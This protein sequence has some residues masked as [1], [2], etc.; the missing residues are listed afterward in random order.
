MSDLPIVNFDEIY[1]EKEYLFK[2]F[3][4]RN[5]SFKD[6]KGGDGPFVYEG[7]C[8]AICRNGMGSIYI[9]FKEY[10]LKAGMM[11]VILPYSIVQPAYVSVDCES[12]VMLAGVNLIDDI[13]LTTVMPLFQEIQ[14][15]PVTTLTP[16]QEKQ[17]TQ[18]LACA[19]RTIAD[20][21][22]PYT[23]EIVRTLL[24]AISLEICSVFSNKER[25]RRP[26][27]R[28]NHKEYIFKQFFNDLSKHYIEHH[29][30]SFY[31]EL[32]YMT[33]KYL[34]LV[35][36]DITGYTASYW[37]DKM[38]ILRAKSLLRHDDISIQQ[39]SYQLNFPNPSFFGQYF[40]KHVGVTPRQFRIA[41]PEESK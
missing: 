31:A 35:V 24:T 15:S 23:R 22:N 16:D 37:I 19:N 39:V 27:D 36:K 26:G 9:N 11:M 8:C 33:P 38:I 25:L 14:E 6:I 21:G 10:E 17:L 4:M 1:G 5:D 12:T 13:H 41:D 29:E 2:S 34:S 40:K 32:Q 18:L 7:F 28:T 30:V 20:E 3:V